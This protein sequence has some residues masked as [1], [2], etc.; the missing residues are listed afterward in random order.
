MWIFIL[1][2]KYEKKQQKGLNFVS[3][4]FLSKSPLLGRPP[5]QK[6][7]P[8]NHMPSSTLRTEDGKIYILQRENDNRAGVTFV[9]LSHMWYASQC[10]KAQKKK[11]GD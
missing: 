8:T 6:D 4:C 7:R 9:S 1:F 2:A 3:F 11:F 10:H 5:P